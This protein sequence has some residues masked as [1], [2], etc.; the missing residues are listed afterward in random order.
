MKGKSCVV[1]TAPFDVRL[2]ERE[3]DSPEDVNTV[4]QPDIMVIVIRVRLM[5]VDVKVHLILIQQ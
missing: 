4:V 5:S 2:F 1:R 3:E